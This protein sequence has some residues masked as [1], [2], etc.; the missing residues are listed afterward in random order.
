MKHLLLFTCLLFVPFNL[1]SAAEFNN[2]DALQGLTATR[3]VFDIN[4]GN[5]DILALRLQL[6]KK[7]YQ[8]LSSAGK[9]PQFVLTFRGKA[10]PF[11][12]AG[13][14]YIDQ[15]DREKKLQI[16]KLLR[17]LNRLGFP[18]EQCAI[19]ADLAKINTNDFLPY[20]TVVAN[21][22]TS[23]IGYQNQGYALISME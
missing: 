2:D 1:V 20:I 4:Q 12:T 8:Q 14:T 5:P 3:A 11:L 23:L 9:N 10:S 16:E 6:I 18:L 15:K 22:Y 7:T 13:K 19:A 21:G 17:Y